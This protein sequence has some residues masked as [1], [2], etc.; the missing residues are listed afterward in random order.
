MAKE[1]HLSDVV[2]F[3]TSYDKKKSN[4]F[5]KVLRYFDYK[6]LRS[7]YTFRDIAGRPTYDL[8]RE[9]IG[10]YQILD[11]LLKLSENSKYEFISIKTQIQ[12]H[13][14]ESIIMD[15]KY[16]ITIVRVLLPEEN[17]T[18]SWDSV[19]K[20]IDMTVNTNEH[21]TIT[22][23]SNDYAADVLN[24]ATYVFDTIL[25]DFWDIDIQDLNKSHISITKLR[26]S[27]LKIAFLYD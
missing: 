15:S 5:Y 25:D 11:R 8:L 24:I 14:S 7:N 4:L 19:L 9:F 1:K 18:I 23:D 20:E 22:G 27:S 13:Q 17:Y 21:Y 10:S 2:N 3:I 12:H 6:K 26:L 16:E